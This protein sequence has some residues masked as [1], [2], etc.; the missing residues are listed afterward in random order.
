YSIG[1]CLASG[2]GVAKNE[3]EAVKW[4]RLAAEQGHADALLNLALCHLNGQGTVKNDMLAYTWFKI[5]DSYKDYD[6]ESILTVLEKRMSPEQIAQAQRLISEWVEKH[7][8][9]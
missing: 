7:K 2:Q 4:Y 6:L 1:L 5:C 9:E 3:A 8:K